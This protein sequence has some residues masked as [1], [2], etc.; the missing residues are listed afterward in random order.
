MQRYVNVC[1]LCSDDD[2]IVCVGLLKEQLRAKASEV[3]SLPI[4]RLVGVG[5]L[6]DG[7][8]QRLDTIVHAL[9][10]RLSSLGPVPQGLKQ[11]SGH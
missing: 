2:E 5:P 10:K 11:R 8:S 6:K 1:Q 7:S 4:V 9:C 3:F